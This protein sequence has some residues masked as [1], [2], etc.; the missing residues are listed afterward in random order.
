M[1]DKIK[2]LFL[3]K[4][5]AGVNYF[6]TQTPAI[7]LER[8]YSDQFEV[9][10]QAELNFNDPEVIE[11]L[12]KYNIIH[13]HQRLVDDI[14]TMNNVKAKLPNIKFVLDIDDYW[15]LDKKHPLY[16]MSIEHK[17]PLI[18]VENLKLADFV[19]T[20]TEA[21]AEE[22]RKVT[23]KDNVFVLYN[24]VNPETMKQFENNWKPDPKGRVRITYAGGSSHM[25]D[26][27]QLESVTNMLNADFQLKDKFTIKLAGWDTEGSINTVSFNPELIEALKAKNLW[28]M[29]TVKILNKSKGNIEMITK[30]PNAVKD[31]FRNNVF[32][33]E[34][35]PIK[36]EESVY[37]YYEQILTDNHKIIKDKDYYNW[38]MSF[39]KMNY[40]GEEG[41]YARRWTQKANIYAK[42]LDETD[43]VIAPL[44]NNKFN[45]MKSN[46]KQVE[47]WTRKLP[48]V[49]SDMIPYNVDG[50]HMENCILI[51]T[52]KN[53]RKHWVKHLKKLI[54]DADLRKKLGEQLYEDFKVKY[55]LETVSKTRAEAYKTILN[56]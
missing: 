25:G 1:S 33:Q 9:D 22:I 18:T 45:T 6:R 42:V 7:E 12:K 39:N 19:T 10:I 14:R 26:I 44:D 34:Q 55:N 17:L 32:K 35:L 50:R 20:T 8:L 52:E 54:L 13:Y 40:F 27:K 23:G 49:F 3:N 43:I 38:L 15:H 4:D 11:G 29:D 31:Q 41:I 37:Y 53:A 30:L 16:N 46:L 51:P 36:S 2:I 48:I 21:F 5:G 24:A 56:A 28:T 47:C